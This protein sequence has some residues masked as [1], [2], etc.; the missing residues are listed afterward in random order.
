MSPL[1]SVQQPNIV[2]PAPAPVKKQSYFD[3]LDADSPAHKMNDKAKIQLMK[4]NDYNSS[5]KALPTDGTPLDKAQK[6]LLTKTAHNHLNALNSFRLSLDAS[7]NNDVKAFNEVKNE[8]IGW[9]KDMSD[10]AT[11]HGLA[12]KDPKTPNGN[13]N[14]LSDSLE[15]TGKALSSFFNSVGEALKKF[16]TPKAAASNSPK[17]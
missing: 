17:P 10:V 8:V 6:S 2:T 4:L 12:K 3:G 11:K 13:S 1:M 16:T 9:H 15:S 7:D 5:L 14:K